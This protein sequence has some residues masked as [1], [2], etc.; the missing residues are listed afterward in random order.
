MNQALIDY[1]RCPEEFAEFVLAGTLSEVSGYFRFGRNAICYGQCSAGFLAPKPTDGLYDALDDVTINGSAL[2]LPFNPTQIVEN[3]RRERY[4]SDVL[5]VQPKRALG[6]MIRDAYY[7]VRPLLPVS[8]RRH[9]QRIHLR[10]WHQIPFPHWPVDR[11]VEL[12][13]ENLLLL[14]MKS[15]GIGRIPFI[16]FWPEGVPSCAIITHDVETTVGRDFSSMLMDINDEYGIKTSFQIVPEKRYKVTSSYLESI[17][18]RGFEINIQ[19]LNHDGHLFRDHTEFLRR[20]ERINRYAKEYGAR[21]FRAAVLYR[22]ADWYDALEIDYDMSFPNVAHLDP[23]RGGCCTMM[24][25]FIGKILELPVTTT[26]DYS[27]FQILCDYSIELWKQQIALIL[28]KH[29]LISFIVHP[30][31]IISEKARG[32]YRT[33]LGYLTQLRSKKKIWIALPN[34]VNR[35]W[36]ERS[37]MQL[38][39]HGDSWRIEGPGAERARVAYAEMDGERLAYNIEPR[40]SEYGGAA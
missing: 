34:E 31:Y 16:W 29:G 13:M 7:L 3:L 17:R 5:R 10:D 15:K 6:S 24:P 28:E 1:Y 11:T 22:N 33:L 9:V 20:V 21:G 26:Q 2:R 38:V 40:P 27:L 23:Q 32:T 14:S 4:F 35:W 36:R 8:I 19:D 12:I 39:G 18:S 25:Y 37:Q 30:D